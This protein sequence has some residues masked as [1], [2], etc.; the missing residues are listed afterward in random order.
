MAKRRKKKVGLQ[1]KVSTVFKGVSLPQRDD[2]ERAGSKPTPDGPCDV[3]SKPVPRDTLVSK[4]SLM[5]KVCQSE[6]SSD[7]AVKKIKK[8]DLSRRKASGRPASQGSSTQKP[9]RAKD[10][11]DKAAKKTKKTVASKRKATDQSASQGSSTQKPARAKDKPDKTT[12]GRITESAPKLTDLNRL[13]PHRSSVEKPLKARD[14]SDTATPGRTNGVPPKLTAP[15]D[16]IQKCTFE[17]EPPR[18]ED[19]LDVA[20][21]DSTVEIPPEETVEDY[22]T[23]QPPTVEGAPQVK[24]SSDEVTP[25]R[26]L[27]VPSWIKSPEYADLRNSFVDKTTLS[28]DSSSQETSDFADD[29]SPIARDGSIPQH[30]SVEEEPQQVENVSDKVAPGGK[31]WVPPK[32][33]T[34]DHPISKASLTKQTERAERPNETEPGRMDVSDSQKHA[35]DEDPA[36]Q[37]SLVKKLY[38]TESTLDL[39]TPDRTTEAPS[40][41]KSVDTQSSQNSRSEKRYGPEA[42]PKDAAPSAQHEAS[43]V[44][45]QS[46]PGLWQQINDRLFTPKPGVST[47]RQKVMMVSI[48]ILVIV[49]IFAFRQVLSKSP[50]KTKGIPAEDVALVVEADPGHEIDWQIPEPLPATMRDP[51]VLPVQDNTRTEEQKQ[52]VHLPKAKLVD[53]GSIVYSHDRPSAIVN[54]RIVHVGEQVSGVT[55][56]KINRDSVE[57]EKDGEKWIQK[58]RD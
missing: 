36:S 49:L 50:R 21:P 14:L 7:K 33:T 2:D 40:T 46:G 30:F 18:T 55:V 11:P 52:P 51:T 23:P 20:E 54:G 12:L 34:P 24:D 5:K 57:F 48:P 38:Q 29:V 39:S 47:A 16:L 22:P 27:S 44:V 26:A 9:A 13:I 28:E 43:L 6:S 42:P 4:S 10:K 56:L 19:L 15:D 3:P 31:S 25:D 32:L 1:K 37:S 17:K 53:L 8:T 41:S 45:E 35:V 58:K